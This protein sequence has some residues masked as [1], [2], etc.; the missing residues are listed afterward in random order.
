MRTWM[1][2]VRETPS[3]YGKTPEKTKKKPKSDKQLFDDLAVAV[4]AKK[5]AELAYIVARAAY[6]IR[7][8][9][10]LA[11]GIEPEDFGA[12]LEG[13]DFQSQLRREQIARD[14]FR[15]PVGT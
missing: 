3:T 12:V 10:R 9:E 8:V 6:G 15:P 2:L 11:A 14:N 5:D 4:E 7:R 13:L 1:D